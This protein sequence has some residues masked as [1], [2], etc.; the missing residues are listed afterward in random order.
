M[1]FRNI[2]SK[3]FIRIPLASV[4]FIVTAFLLIPSG[5]FL[6]QLAD[7]D[8]LKIVGAIVCMGALVYS[9]ALFMN[10]R[11]TLN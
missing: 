8:I 6:N 2:L 11:L 5:S 3:D 7:T 9:I 1:L 4:I 10:I